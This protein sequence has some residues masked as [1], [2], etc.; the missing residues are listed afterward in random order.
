[1]LPDSFVLELISEYRFL[2]WNDFKLDHR[3]TR[4]FLENNIVKETKKKRYNGRSKRLK[5]GEQLK[6][7]KLVLRW[8]DSGISTALERFICFYL[9]KFLTDAFQV[10]VFVSLSH[11]ENSSMA[12]TPSALWAESINTVG[13]KLCSRTA[14]NKNDTGMINWLAFEDQPSTDITHGSVALGGIWTTET[15]CEKVVFSQ[16]RPWNWLT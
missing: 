12:H 7:N 2:S 16:V 4:C 1:M 10:H 14:G 8:T 15:K 3:S 6:G 11:E 9:Y 13:F 5:Q